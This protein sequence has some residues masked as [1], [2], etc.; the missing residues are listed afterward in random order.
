MDDLEKS[1]IS[2]MNQSSVKTSNFSIFSED[3]SLQENENTYL[4]VNE[5]A[6]LEKHVIDFNLSNYNF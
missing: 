2:E 6:A 1:E 3:L 5:S 4:I